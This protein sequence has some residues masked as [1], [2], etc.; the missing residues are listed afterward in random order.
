MQEEKAIGRKLAE[1]HA[2]IGKIILRTSIRVLL[3]GVI[4]L[5]GVRGNP[6]QGMPVSFLAGFVVVL[7]A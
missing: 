4:I 7:I 5:A 3:A 2:N 6:P 1:A